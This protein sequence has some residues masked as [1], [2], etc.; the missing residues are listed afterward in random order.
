MILY[1][2]FLVISRL[3]L[4]R[5]KWQWWFGMF[6]FL[7]IAYIGLQSKITTY[8]KAGPP[9]FTFIGVLMFAK[10]RGVLELTKRYK[11]LAVTSAVCMVSL[12]QYVYQLGWHDSH[13]AMAIG[14][15][16]V[17]SFL[18]FL[19]LNSILNISKPNNVISWVAG[20]SYE[21]YQVHAPLIS[22]CGYFVKD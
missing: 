18:S 15:F 8:S 21:I 7:T 11:W 20:V 10:G 13:K 2:C 1:V 5:I 9:L 12:S 22:I 3:R 4:D 6:A 16:I 19:A 17:A 14:S